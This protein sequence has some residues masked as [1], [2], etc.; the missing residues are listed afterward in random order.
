MA[1]KIN[2][3]ARQCPEC[4]QWVVPTPKYNRFRLHCRY[5][6]PTDGFGYHDTCP[7][8]GTS[9][10]GLPAP[11]APP[12]SELF[13]MKE[14]V[15]RAVRNARPHRCTESARWVA[16]RDVFGYGS[17]TSISLCDRFG[18]DPHEMVPGARCSCDEG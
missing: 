4:K 14:L 11:P 17:S 5:V 3:K 6:E 1:I 15:E 18:L 12:K 2:P 10:D 9:A 7:G 8:S 16:V 13:A